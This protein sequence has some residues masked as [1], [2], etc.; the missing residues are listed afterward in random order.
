MS[1]SLP[2]FYRYGNTFVDEREKNTVNVY[3]CLSLSELKSVQISCHKHSAKLVLASMGT[4]YTL[5]LPM[6]TSEKT[7]LTRVRVFFLTN[8]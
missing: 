1:M 5:I 6:P 8:Y 2:V 4:N 3:I 7:S